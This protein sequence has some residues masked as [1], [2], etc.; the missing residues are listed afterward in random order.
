MSAIYNQPVS[1]QYLNAEIRGKHARFAYSAIDT[2]RTLSEKIKE[3]IGAR[4]DKLQL[5]ANY[6]WKWCCC[7]IVTGIKDLDSFVNKLKHVNYFM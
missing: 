4:V 5:F 2:A 3:A 6:G 7:Q 1:V